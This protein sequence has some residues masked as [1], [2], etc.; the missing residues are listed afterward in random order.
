[1]GDLSGWA[2]DWLGWRRTIDSVLWGQAGGEGAVERRRGGR[3]EGAGEGRD[4][5]LSW[6]PGE[7]GDCCGP[8]QSRAET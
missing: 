6:V 4:G 3:R 2:G 8:S 5:P 1:M 7:E